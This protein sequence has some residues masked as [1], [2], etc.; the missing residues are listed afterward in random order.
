[1]KKLVVIASVVLCAVQS[2][3]QGQFSF[4]NFLLSPAA[5]IYVGVV[6]GT[7]AGSA[8]SVEYAYLAQPG[9]T[10]ASQLNVEGGITTLN[11]GIFSGP[12]V[13]VASY[14]GT[15]SLQI[16][17][18][19][20]ADGATYSAAASSGHTGAS[21][22]MQVS[23]GN[24]NAIPPGTATSLAGNL[25]SFAVAVPEPTTIALGVMGLSVL[26]FRRRK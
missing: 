22:I 17:A 10:D 16:R 8:Y 26:L 13:T 9:V 12:D 21:T 15:I 11:N 18:W 24:P 2:H 4:S 6:G 23:L 7:K 19:L 14:V 1:M 25:S 5:P 3:A 20:T